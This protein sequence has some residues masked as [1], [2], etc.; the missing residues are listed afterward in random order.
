[1]RCDRTR[2]ALMERRLELLDAAG[3]RE[4]A[5]HLE[6][7]PACRA[8]EIEERLLDDD[9]AGLGSISPV[10][11]NLAGRVMAEVRALGPVP[12]VHVPGRH[13]AA[14][15]AA[16]AV[17]AFAV[18]AGGWSNLDLVPEAVALV[19]TL[20][21]AL[22]SVA[23]AALVIPAALFRAVTGLAGAL[24]GILAGF[25]PLLRWIVPASICATAAVFATVTLLTTVMVGRELVPSGTGRPKG[26][27][28]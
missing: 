12:R 24:T 2:H 3:Q 20:L 5:R 19:G 16:A 4:L 7:C 8:V 6:R 22:G 14:S 15:F 9:L 1:M 27:L 11:V 26:E 18:I 25:A 28:R 21:D 17:L 10:R 13:L 23:S